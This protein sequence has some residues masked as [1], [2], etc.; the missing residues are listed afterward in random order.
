MT[1]SL[2]ASAG[3][4]ERARLLKRLA[5]LENASQALDPGANRRKKLRT[6]AF[7]SAERFL[8]KLHAS[9]AYEETADKGAGLLSAPIS[10]RGISIEAAIDLFDREVLKPGGHPASGGY[11]AYI[12]GGGLYHSAVAD[13]L[14]AVSDKYAGIFFAGPGAVRME[15]MLVRWVADL[16]G[17]PA[18][19]GGHIA[20]GGRHTTRSTKRCAS[21]DLAKPSFTTSL[22]TSVFGCEQ[23]R[24]KLRLHPT[25]R[26]D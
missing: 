17:Y 3:D 4:A 22:P 7:A 11:L 18:G 26:M 15:N 2:D 14:A 6:A 19:A 16:I 23:M 5:E 10:E 20:S 8:R 1:K 13:F 24:S 25:A 9:K 21:L 12:P